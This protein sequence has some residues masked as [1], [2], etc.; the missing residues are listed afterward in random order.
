MTENTIWLPAASGI[1]LGSSEVH[2]WRASLVVDSTVR[3]R[4][5]AVLSTAEQERAARF[6][7]A[8]DRNRYAVAR[9]ILR[10]LLGGY[11]REAPQ[12]VVSGPSLMES[13][14]SQRLP[15]FPA[16]VSTSR[17]R[18]SSPFSLFASIM[19]SEST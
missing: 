14:L 9:G 7:F 1:Q 2:I 19:N 6:S 17:I 3:D 12:D 5:C 8:R 13:L 11:L 4:L 10:Q 16:C 15:E 18:T